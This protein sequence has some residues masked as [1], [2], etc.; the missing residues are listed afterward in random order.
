M[1]RSVI[2]VILMCAAM[3]SA[4]PEV[5]A[6]EA[7]VQ[8]KEVV[9][10]ADRVESPAGE[11]TSDV[12][13]IKGDT[14]EKMNVKFVAD[15]LREIPDINLIQNG[16][17]G[18]TATVL[19]RG[20][21][22]SQTLV[23]I[24]G[25]KV[26]STT[27]GSYDFSGLMAGDI[28]RIEIVKG[29]QS[30]LYGSEA[31]SG[32]IN[33][34][35]KKGKGEAR[36][37]A[38]TEAGSFNTS[39]SSLSVSGGGEKTDYRLTGSYLYTDGIS[40]A[41]QG[42]E[43]DG[44]KN[45]AV[46]GKFGLKPAENLELD[47]SGKYYHDRAELDDFDFL[48]RQPVDNPNYVQYGD[49]SIVSGKG[50]L[51]L[52]NAWEQ[53]LTVSS[54]LDSLRGRDP[55]VIFNN[56]DIKTELDTVDW[57]NNL[58]L[59]DLSTLTVGIETQR[60]KGENKGNFA[61]SIY[62]DAW[63]LN[64]RAKFLQGSLILNAGI[65]HDATQISGSKTTYRA[66]AL[67]DI[68]SIALKVKGNYGTGFRAPS[69]NELFFPFFG[70]LNLKPEESRGWDLGLEKAFLNNR[71]VAA[72]TYFDQKY[73]NL[74]EPD[75]N[76]PFT[77]VNIAR[78]EIKGVETSVTVRPIDTVTVKAGQTYLDARDKD[79]GMRLTLRPVDKFTLATLYSADRV[80]ATVSYVFVGER[81]DA[82]TQRNLASYNLVNVSGNYTLSKTITLFARIDNVFN[83]NYEEAGGYGT[84]GL[85][86]FGGVKISLL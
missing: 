71:A 44:Y 18:Q 75:P 47:F 30:T 55:I 62:N 14:I 13:V 85:S 7:S 10:T 23:M 41:K 43:R 32:V 3:V 16:G 86:A 22:S 64:D 34:I 9:V 65:R 31:M 20:G 33:I 42:T 57:Q 83:V 38:T 70:N 54:V 2:G 49:H 50:K 79:T 35:T 61:T 73:N 17:P 63:Y 46:S 58:F 40:A 21:N 11:T 76:P 72:I 66:G 67:Y 68:Q 74:I 25:V 29:P 6:E 84:P 5:R 81:F 56:Y 69:L 59:S 37:D 36:I 77:A 15:V 48:A 53:I 51:Y 1:K 12:T 52:F 27:V 8:L 80:S 45:A 4:A 28:E 78:A 60:Q 39:N 82:Q 24:D 19:L 26:K